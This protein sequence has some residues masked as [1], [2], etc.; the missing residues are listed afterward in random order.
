MPSVGEESGVGTDLESTLDGIAA[1]AAL[2]ESLAGSSVMLDLYD[3]F[4][5]PSA[6]PFPTEVGAGGGVGGGG[7]HVTS[8]PMEVD[9]VPPPAVTEYPGFA[10]PSPLTTCRPQELMTSSLVTSS[11]A[12]SAEHPLMM[13]AAATGQ[14]AAS[15][16]EQFAAVKS[17]L[18]STHH[19]HYHPLSLCQSHATPHSMAVSDF[20][21][22]AATGLATEQPTSTGGFRY[23]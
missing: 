4:A 22:S 20:R 18:T 16:L 9:V 7:D 8:T 17:T 14:A 15:A 6:F 5:N 1:S 3:V 21:P 12:V 19:H 23:V 11:T 13:S 2:F 10:P